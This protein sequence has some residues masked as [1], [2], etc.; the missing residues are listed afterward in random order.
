MA[1]L[2]GAVEKLKQMMATEEGQANIQ[3]I[4]SNF[5][6]NNAESPDSAEV[7]DTETSDNS[8]SSSPF[9]NIDMDMVMK[10]QKAFSKMNSTGGSV[11]GN[12]RHASMLHSLKPYLSDGRK[13]KLDMAAKLMSLAKFAPLMKD[14]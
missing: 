6:L 5:S 2:S 10:M 9:G 7:S 13:G 1:D 8:D 12:S 3:N 11:G 4:I 14:L